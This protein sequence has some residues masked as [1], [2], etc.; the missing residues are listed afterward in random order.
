MVHY[1]LCLLRSEAEIIDFTRGFTVFDA[2]RSIEIN[3]RAAS[4][5]FTK[6]VIVKNDTGWAEYHL[7]SFKIGF[8]GENIK[9]RG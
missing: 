2:G 7:K 3:F 4:N 5:S 6:P 9:N 8:S 1:V